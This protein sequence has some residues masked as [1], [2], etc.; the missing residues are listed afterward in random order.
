MCLNNLNERHDDDYKKKRAARKGRSLVF[1]PVDSVF[2]SVKNERSFRKF[3]PKRIDVHGIDF[4]A[5]PAFVHSCLPP[6]GWHEFELGIWPVRDWANRRYSISHTAGRAIRNDRNHRGCEESVP[7]RRL[8]SLWV[9]E[10]EDLLSEVVGEIMPHQ[11]SI[12]HDTSY[13][14]KLAG[15]ENIVNSSFGLYYRDVKHSYPKLLVVLGPTASG[16]TALG[17]RIAK[18]FGG[19]VIS[20]DSRQVYRGMDIGTAKSKHVVDGV[21]HHL[22]DV[23]DPDAAFS[24]AEWKRMA[25]AAAKDIIERGHI[26]IVVGGTGLYIQAIV[27]NV[28]PPNIAP[29]PT[30]RATLEKKSLSELVTMLKRYDP[31]AAKRIDIKNSRRVIRALE[32]AI[33]TG[34]PFHSQQ[35]KGKPLF[36][37]LQ[38]GIDVPRDELYRRIDERV[39]EQIKQ[40]LVDEV[41]RLVDRYAPD[42]PSLTAIGYRQ[43]VAHLQGKMTLAQAIERIKF[44]THAYARRQ[45]TW[46][47]KDKRIQWISKPS[48]AE[49]CVEVFLSKR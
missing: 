24:V 26:P 3:D 25:V 33:M 29:N 2:T 46:F 30:L 9:R 6:I 19:E 7:I 37:A 5:H 27:D 12:E 20:A 28:E 34:Q 36:E 11:S 31:D 13:G 38:I 49:R 47:R 18:K 41:R 21:R 43:I 42:I 14:T 22:I 16:K 40:G 35:K 10:V 8:G 45:M 15:E 32:V 17:I 44:D 1:A 4:A 39:D 23:V 48:E